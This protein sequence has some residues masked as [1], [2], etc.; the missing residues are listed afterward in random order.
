M[1][2]HKKPAQLSF[3]TRPGAHAKN[4]AYVPAFSDQSPSC[5]PASS[6]DPSA[7]S[8]PAPSPPAST[9]PTFADNTDN[10]AAALLRIEGSVVAVPHHDPD[11]GFFIART[12]LAAARG[13]GSPF[14]GSATLVGKASEIFPGERFEAFGRWVTHPRYGRQFR[15]ERLRLLHPLTAH[16]MTRYLSSGAVAGIGK[17]LAQRLVKVHG[18]RLSAVLADDVDALAM[19]PGLSKKK[20]LAIQ[21]AWNARLRHHETA[22]FLSGLGFGSARIRSIM[23][24]YAG[25]DIPALLKQ[26][27]YRL[28]GDVR[29]IGFP[30]ADSVA[31][32]LGVIATAPSRLRAGILHILA[33]AESVGHCGL[34]RSTLLEQACRLLDCNRQDVETALDL[35]F[36]HGRIVE[37]V[38]DLGD[39]H[40]PVPVILHS[41]TE[42]CECTIARHVLR[43]LASKPSWDVA[44][45]LRINE[46]IQSGLPDPLSAGQ[47]Q[48]LV[49]GLS[50]RL[51]VIT[52][53]PGT[54]KTY[55][56]KTLL[57]ILS[58]LG[59]RFA[60]CSPTGKAA[61]RAMDST[62]HEASTVHRLLEVQ[63][64]RDGERFAYNSRRRLEC[65]VVVVDEGSMQDVFL[66][67]SLIEAL[68]DHASLIIIGDVDQLPSVGP[69]QILADMIRSGVVPVTRLTE[70]FRQAR[71][72]KIIVNAHRINS[73]LDLLLPKRGEVSDFYFMRCE[74]PDT[75]RTLIVDLVSRR[76]P[77][78][79]GFNPA[80]DIQILAPMKNGSA[81]TR[82]LNLALQER[83]SATQGPCIKSPS[84]FSL[85]RGDRVIQTSND[86]DLGVF[87][88]DTGQ[89]L[90]LDHED[91]SLV[92][93]F[94]DG[95]ERRYPFESLG[96]LQLAYAMT[97]HKSQGSE[98]PCVILPV[99]T[100]HY[101]M[102]QR[103]LL[104]TGIT[105]GKKL[106]IV[107]GQLQAV[108]LAARN[109]SSQSR[110]TSLYHFL[111]SDPARMAA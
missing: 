34:R 13:G 111:R 31:R 86:Y 59:V 66:M 97:I 95:K 108:R 2:I 9:P 72:S 28:V 81:G 68:P 94:D 106:V 105:R 30:M 48:A 110:V 76:L 74:D 58:R 27:P 26:D 79:Y 70:I 90:S 23:N 80:R 39:G 54:G 41:R 38:I 96:D 17:R 60:L 24:R 42:R 84:G 25:L 3:D 40:A 5:R 65:D 98:F 63:S 62:G 104:Y 88:G 61:K 29:G 52:G 100:S 35:E 69:G 47:A 21:L 109:T 20:A 12:D 6:R 89:V 103:N 83:L 85:Y 51:S 56:T 92:I 36:L 87:N 46:E 8:S 50:N 73:G 32:A 75:A 44:R 71:N 101:A 64:G 7:S 102:L 37:H 4:Q 49:M 18:D 22:G 10:A 78:H 55:V 82:S 107:V 77:D 43:L 14:S 33:E 53:N 19:I 93:A 99:L 57:Q 15:S 67:R 91:N 1:T 11:S 16:A 45:A